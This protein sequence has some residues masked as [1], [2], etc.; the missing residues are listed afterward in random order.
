LALNLLQAIT[1][2]TDFGKDH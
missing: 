1:E 2:V